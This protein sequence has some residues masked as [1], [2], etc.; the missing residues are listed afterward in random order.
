[1]YPIVVMLLDGL[2]EAWKPVTSLTFSIRARETRPQMLQVVARV[3]TRELA[4]QD[5][6]PAAVLP[7]SK[8]I[9]VLMNQLSDAD[10]LRLSSEEMAAHCRCTVRHFQRLFS[11]TFG[12]AVRKKQEQLRLLKAGQILVETK[13]KVQDVAKEVHYHD[14]HTIVREGEEGDSM[15]VIVEGALIVFIIKYR[16]GKRP[17]KP[18]RTT[19]PK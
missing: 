5:P 17:R 10:F 15:F 12:V 2:A 13:T 19:L 1:V 6:A 3:F 7:A 4:Q 18:Y 14:G 16:R 8:R 11:Q 9:K